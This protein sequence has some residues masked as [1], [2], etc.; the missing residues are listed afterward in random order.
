G[1]AR[2][3]ALAGWL[4]P[5]ATAWEPLSAIA[6]RAVGPAGV[7]LSA[8]VWL[9]DSLPSLFGL[10]SGLAAMLLGLPALLGLSV[11]LVGVVVWTVYSLVNWQ[12]WQRG[13][14]AARAEFLEAAVN[15]TERRLKPAPVTW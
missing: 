6:P 5:G 14:T 3:R 1:L 10:V 12:W 4:D 13:D 2:D 9:R 8:V 7:L 15:S 11:V